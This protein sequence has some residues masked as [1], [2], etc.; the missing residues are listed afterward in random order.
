[1]S[2]PSVSAPFQGKRCFISGATGL[3]GGQLTEELLKQG[4]EVVALVRDWR[5]TSFLLASGPPKG[6]TVVRGELSDRDLLERVLFDYEITHVFH[7]A[8][9][10]RVPIARV[11]PLDTFEANVRG[12]WILMEALRRYGK[13]ELCLLASSDKIYGPLR[14]LPYTESTRPDPIAPYDTSKLCSEL[15]ACS[16][17]R[18]FDIPLLRT[19][20]GNLYGPGDLNWDRLIPGTL[21]SLIRGEAPVIRSDG[22]PRRDFVYVGDGARLILRL[23]EGGS[24][25]SGEVYNIGTG[26]PSSVL[27]VVKALGDAVG[28]EAPEPLI[29]GEAPGEIQDQWLDA[30]RLEEALGEVSYMSLREGIA[31]T[32]PWYQQLL[33]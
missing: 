10:T 9:Q 29:L 15:V 28:G 27:E 22:S 4:A 17:A 6:V 8:A 30:T 31:Q 33:G 1:M 2:R 14:D 12:T 11:H 32:L 5:P 25:R 18:S 16:Y 21:R 7:L 19:R 3:L 23:M 13:V 24:A 26:E 20:C